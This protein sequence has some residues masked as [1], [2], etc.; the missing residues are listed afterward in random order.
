MVF[1]RTGFNRWCVPE[2]ERLPVIQSSLKA[3]PNFKVAAHLSLI[4]HYLATLFLV[5]C[6]FIHSFF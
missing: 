6:V 1:K 3:I 5:K 2:E 4:G